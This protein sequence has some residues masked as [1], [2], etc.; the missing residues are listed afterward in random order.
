MDD[1]LN[2]K[3]NQKI[4]KYIEGEEVL[5]SCHIIKKTL[6]VLF[7]KT[8]G[9]N[10]LITNKAVYNLKGTS[11]ERK[12]DFE[13]IVAITISNKSDEFIIHGINNEYD[14]LYI[15]KD[16]KKIIKILQNA[17]NALTGRNLLF[18]IKDEKNID[19]FV[20]KKKEREKDP[21]SSKIKDFKFIPIGDYL[22]NEKN[23]NSKII[24]QKLEAEKGI[25][26]QINGIPQ[27]Q[28]PPK[29]P[30]KFV[31]NKGKLVPLPPPPPPPPQSPPNISPPSDNVQIDEKL[32][33]DVTTEVITEINEV[34]SVTNVLQEFVNP[35]NKPLEL[36]IYIYKKRGMIFD[37][38]TTKIG[39]SIMAKSKII[40]KEKA[41]IKYTDSISS[42]NA[43]I[44]VYED[45]KD[46]KLIINMG[47]IPPKEKIIFTSRFISIIESS[48]KL[49]F[50]I[51]RNF[52][53]LQVIN[54]ICYNSNLKG[55]INI[56]TQNKIVKIEKEILMNNL[57]IINEKYEDNIAKNE[58]LI[59]YEINNLPKFSFDNL[60]YIPCSKIY[61]DC[62]INYPTLY[63]QKSLNI[64]NEINYLFRYKAQKNNTN[65]LENNPG[66]FIFLV[67]QSGSMSGTPIKI[68]SKAL[69][70]FLQSLPAGSF[71]QIIGFGSSFKK[72]DTDPKEYTKQNLQK[73]L[74][75]IENLKADLGGT[76][77]Y[78]PLNDIYMS[79]KTYEKIQLPKNIFLLTDGEIEDKDKVLDI[80]EINSLEYRIFSIGIGNYFDKDL[81]KNAGI[82]GKGYYNFCTNLNELN[83]IIASEINRAVS[84][85]IKI[86]NIHCSLD[87]KNIIKNIINNKVL[88]ENE[89]M[90]LSYIIENNQ[91]EGNINFKLNYLGS[92]NNQK[93]KLYNLVPIELKEGNELSK[94]IINDYI[95]HNLDLEEEKILKLALKYQIFTKYTSL[96]AEIELSDKISKEMKLEMIGN[97]KNNILTLQKHQSHPI[98]YTQELP[99][100]KL[101]MMTL[102]ENNYSKNNTNYITSSSK[103]F[104]QNALSNA[105]M[106]RRKNLKVQ[107]LDSDE[108]EDDWDDVGYQNYVNEDI[109]DKKEIKKEEKKVENFSLD[110]KESIMK[111]IYTQDFI[112]GYWEENEYTKIIKEKYHKEYNSLKNKQ[113]NDKV[114]ITILVILFVSKEYKEMLNDLLMIFKKAK[115]FI[116]KEINDSYENIIN[117]INI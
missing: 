79:H 25:K 10:L 100:L 102:P 63:C 14:H 39:D 70:I 68:A 1:Q 58:Y 87:S 15:S 108:E 72:Y 65:S 82:M 51:F 43:A 116:Q 46:N 4:K 109:E 56:K 55:K 84:D 5:F 28:S 42:G 16:R 104:L 47:N 6:N 18:S 107:D 40:K 48:Q 62:E 93:E 69:K 71:Y 21:N 77:I 31:K 34:Y 7:Q 53:I 44:F 23:E 114:I 49:E 74:Q 13:N 17:F 11:I 33:H 111:M 90:N 101:K 91:F 117:E 105:I 35:Y 86:S 37:S 95:L 32:K 45:S 89:I 61:F 67:D 106:N 30:D 3:N 85:N 12:I 81:I 22:D 54:K 97:V 66:V 36:K 96:F 110:D 41:E 83:S 8:L 24:K 9:I 73:T 103:N 2:L 50:E 80:I 98:D 99:S 57:K 113:F 64:Q 38:F 60:E 112:E 59:E 27:P 94:L 92:N 115:I 20:M 88:R 76:D 52:P 19:K 78:G 75:I 26:N 29:V